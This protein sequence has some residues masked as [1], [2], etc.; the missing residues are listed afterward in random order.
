MLNS[1]LR[2]ARISQEIDLTD[3]FL[4]SVIAGLGIGL[5]YLILNKIVGAISRRNN[6]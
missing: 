5:G 3:Q 2:E 1:R 6:G 4:G